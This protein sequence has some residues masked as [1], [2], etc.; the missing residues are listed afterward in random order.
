MINPVLVEVLRGGFVESRHRG[1]I[2][3][4]D[5]NGKSVLSIGDVG[6]PV[7]PRSAIKLIQALPL[8]ESGAAT[9]YGFGEEQLALACA[10]HNGEVHHVEV[11][12][13]M[14]HA[15]GLDEDALECGPQMPRREVDAAFL[16]RTGERPRRIHN[17]CSGKHSGMLAF[18]RHAG[19]K[20]EGYVKADH[21]VQK[22][23]AHA[24][25]QV[26][27]TPLAT[28]RAGPMVV[29]F[30]PTRFRCAIWRTALRASARSTVLPRSALMPA[31]N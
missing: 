15:A 24:L 26:T 11:A 16:H 21:E 29:P 14:L 9:A 27:G 3:V 31:G 6:R 30:R 22:A 25:E 12:Q 7:F 5:A 13:T 2:E 1:A 23:C 18:A 28:A 10:S 4:C 19:F 17:N 20:T 8:M